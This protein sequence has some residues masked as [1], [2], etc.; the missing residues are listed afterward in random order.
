MNKILILTKSNLRKNRG[1]VAGLFILV[2]ILSM[3]ISSALLMFFD[4]YPS[5]ERTAKHLNSG[6]GYF[7]LTGDLSEYDDTKLEELLSEN[8]TDWQSRRLLDYPDVSV[9]Y[10]KGS[11]NPGLLISD[12]EA[13]YTEKDK[14]EIVDEDP[15]VTGKTVYLPYQFYTG[16][17]YQIG[18][19]FSIILGGRDH[20]FRVKGFHNTTWF[21]CSNQSYYELIVDDDTYEALMEADKDTHEAVLTVFD[22]KEG[23]KSG[24]FMIKLSN[25]AL[26]SNPGLSFCFKLLDKALFSR[27]F[28]SLIMAVSFLVMT[29]VLLGVVALMLGSSIGNY[30]RENMKMI[31][32][33]KAIGYV[34]MDIR[35]SLLFTFGLLA[36]TGSVI[37]VVLGYSSMP[38]MSKIVISQMGIPYTPG[39]SPMVILI[40]VCAVTAFILL[41]TLLATIRIRKVEPILALREGLE[42]H[43]F[44]KNLVPLSKAPFGLNISLSLKMLTTNLSQNV[45]I[46]F[47]TG[48]LVFVCVVSLMMFDN[49]NLHPNI[50]LLTF[51]YGA[52]V[53]SVD[54]DAKEEALDFLEEREDVS[55]IRRILNLPLNYKDQDTLQIYI[56]DDGAKI[57]NQDIC[58]DGRFPKYDNEIAVSG[59]FASEYGY[60]IGDEI[61]M[62][63]GDEHYDYII[64]GLIQTCNNFGR[65]GM[66]TEEGAERLLDLEYLPVYYWFD[67]PEGSDKDDC[68]EVFTAAKAELGE[69]IQSTINV[70]TTME[71]GMDLFKSVAGLM[72]GL[73]GVVSAAVITLIFYLLL[74]SLLYR[75]RKEYGIYKALGFTSFDLMIQTALS[76]MP[77]MILSVI[78]FSVVSYYLANPYMSMML[79]AFGLMKSTFTIP[80]SGVILTG[81]IMVLFAFA[82]AL[83]MSSRIRK[84]EAYRMLVAE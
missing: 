59:R 33:L 77:V 14:T 64:S 49:F 1:T 53:L 45:I 47:V 73:M 51:E 2:V 8:M 81:V 52:G 38:L 27:T 17:G 15:S 22:F 25:T 69:H 37:G 5:M 3:L 43:N 9:H 41:I 7:F 60:V 30:I 80:I 28:V 16:G 46:F 39:F 13:F 10:G 34:S 32:A 82:M 58:Y 19:D 72:L 44:R 68:E 18:D 48:L 50:G 74:K 11:V 76:F 56:V 36:L 57:N 40:T 26:A 66:M 65:E 24:E 42:S 63:Y 61:E 4:A 55:N 12:S 78:I 23:V 21:G 71:G 54:Q 62:V 35:A 67:L 29:T 83:L 20:T 79:F 6:D 70:Y 31:G 84:I 75:R